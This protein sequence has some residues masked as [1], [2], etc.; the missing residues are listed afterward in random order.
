MERLSVLH[1]SREFNKKGKLAGF[2]HIT[3][4]LMYNRICYKI[5]IIVKRNSSLFDLA[6]NRVMV[7]IFLI[8]LQIE[9]FDKRDFFLK[10]KKLSK[11][12]I[13]RM[14][15]PFLSLKHIVQ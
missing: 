4:V 10:K 3:D 11:N 13:S 12:V 5:V 6:G 1:T 9:A 2:S 7:Q 8:D 15:G 14:G